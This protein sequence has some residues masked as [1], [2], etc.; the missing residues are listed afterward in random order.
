MP[1]YEAEDAQLEILSEDRVLTRAYWVELRDGAWVA[2][3]FSA[4]EMSNFVRAAYDRR[5][6][7]FAT[8]VVIGNAETMSAMIS[9]AR[10]HVE[11]STIV[12]RRSE[13]ANFIAR[14]KILDAS[15]EA[16]SKEVQHALTEYRNTI[17]NMER[18]NQLAKVSQIIG[19]ASSVIGAY[20]GLAE[21]QQ[22]KVENN[23]SAILSLVADIN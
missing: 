14:I 18:L 22:P 11:A 19:A 20:N 15:R 1:K 12:I 6:A 10:A 13:N 17:S 5:R 3:E 4:D 23:Y 8:E 2:R 21:A 16:A 9:N 7:I